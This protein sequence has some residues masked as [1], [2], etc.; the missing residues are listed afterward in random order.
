M[1]LLRLLL[2][3]AALPAL[4]ALAVIQ[5]AASLIVGLSSVVT[6]LMGTLGIAAA[7]CL[8][9]FRLGTDTDAY[10]MLA[11][12][13]FFLILPHMAA[14]LIEKITEICARLIAWIVP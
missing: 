1:F 6:N 8:W 5:F 2:R 7:A 14:W 10:G 3:I 9:M 13:V 4:L 12:G 11:L